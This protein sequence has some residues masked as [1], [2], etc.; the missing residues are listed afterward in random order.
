MAR[1]TFESGPRLINGDDLNN[2]FDR[3]D[4]PSGRPVLFR[5]PAAIALTTS[6]TLTAAQIVNQLL[7]AN[8]GG[9]AAATYTLPTGAIFDAAVSG[10]MGVGDAFELY[11]VNISTTAAETATIAT[12]TGWTL[13]GQM[14]VAANS[15][16][17]TISR[18][19]YLIQKTAASTFTLTRI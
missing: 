1:S 12:A 5:Q 15:A 4:P 9:G 14:Q 10:Y 16:A 18:G 11:L 3:L 7:T 19:R 8:Q 2:N 17:T 6:A 13:V